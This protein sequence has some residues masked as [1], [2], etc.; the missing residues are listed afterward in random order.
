MI[1]M[2]KV[3]IDK[4]IPFIKGVLEPYVDVVYLGGKV[5]TREVVKDADAL[6]IR[7]RTKCNGDMLSGSRVKAIFSATIGTDHIDMAYCKAN[8]IA[9]YSA[10]G[11]NAWGV[12]QYVIT[13]IYCLAERCDMEIDGKVLGIIGAGNVGERLAWL[14]ERLGLRVMRCDPP[15]QERLLKNRNR[16]ASRGLDIDI[17]SLIPANYYELDE[18]LECADIL[19]IHLL[20]DEDTRSFCSEHFFRR[21]KKG[22][23]FI[24]SSRG[25]VVDEGAL[26]KYGDHLGGL[27]IDVWNGEP[28]IN[29]NLL[30]VANIGT[31]HIAGY[32]FEGKINA[33]TM[34]IDSF[35]A[36]FGIDELKGFDISDV[37]SVV[38]TDDVDREF[39]FDYHKSRRANLARIFTS[40]YNILGDDLALR[41][42]PEQFEYLRANYAFRREL[43]DELIDFV[44]L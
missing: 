39:Y 9:V 19:S 32:S 3:V 36:H 11:C 5:I 44:S 4:D 29:L 10:P 33:S 35:A 41:Q 23:I 2:T 14:A 24:N 17:S 31:P 7:T 16:A 6:I 18:V 1:E 27:I 21:V 30:S 40:S 25:E 28:D 8:D 37:E 15:E 43:S 38:D 42:N 22:A 34:V 26:L 20:L 12:V 13:S